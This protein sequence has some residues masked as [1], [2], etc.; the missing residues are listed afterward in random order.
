[1]ASRWGSFYKLLL[2]SGPHPQPW[3]SSVCLTLL[4]MRGLPAQTSFHSTEGEHMLETSQWVEDSFQISLPLPCWI[5]FLQ[6]H[7]H[8]A[9]P[10]A[11]TKGSAWMQPLLWGLFSFAFSS[12]FTSAATSMSEQPWTPAM[13]R[14]ALRA[15][16]CLSLRTL[17]SI[18]PWR[19]R[20][21]AAPRPRNS[22]CRRGQRAPATI[23]TQQTRSAVTTPPFW[24]TSTGMRRAPGGRANPCILASSTRIL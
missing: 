12:P 22:A 2:P 15:A 3:P 16:A 8:W 19:Y 17:P 10:Q 13:T 21:C 23:A 18:A 24:R 7:A 20:M 9:W 4:L 6:L 5:T 11:C 14:R 1:M